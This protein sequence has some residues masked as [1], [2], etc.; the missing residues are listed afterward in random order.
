MSKEGNRNSITGKKLRNQSTALLINRSGTVRPDQRGLQSP[1]LSIFQHQHALPSSHT[2]ITCSPLVTH[3]HQRALPLPHACVSVLSPYYTPVYF[4]ALPPT[5]GRIRFKYSLWFAEARDWQRRLDNGKELAKLLLFFPFYQMWTGFI[6]HRITAISLLEV[7]NSSA[8]SLL[9]L[10]LPSEPLFHG[11]IDFL[12]FAYLPLLIQG[13]HSQARE[14]CIK[15]TL[16]SEART[17]TSLSSIWHSGWFT[18]H[19][20]CQY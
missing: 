2:R 20:F 18:L 19:F 3:P 1:H 5:W 15:L 9:I 13:S 8:K 12:V 17:D 7:H 6:F 14:K 16:L 10:P 11:L 4:S